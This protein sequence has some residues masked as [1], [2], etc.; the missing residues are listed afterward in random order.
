MPD[1]PRWTRRD[2]ALC[3]AL[4][5]AALLVRLP[6]LLTLPAFRDELAEV[7]RGVQIVRDQ[8]YPLVNMTPEIGPLFNYL[9]AAIFSITGPDP[10]LP[11]LVVTLLG[12][13][14]VPLTYALAWMLTGRR[15]VAGIAA[16]LLAANAMHIL[17]GHVAWSNATTPFWTT[18]ALLAL[19]AGLRRNVGGERLH[20][21]RL[22]AAGALWGLAL[23]THPTVIAAL[24]GVGAWLWWPG[25]TVR[26]R[27]RRPAFWV[28]HA[29]FAIAYA[30]PVLYSIIH[31]F[32]FWT[33]GV[34]LKH[35]ALASE[36]T[37]G[38]LDYGGNA[39]ALLVEWV[40]ANAAAVARYD[41]PLRY[42]AEPAVLIYGL[43]LIAGIGW[44]VRA[45]L[46]LLLAPIL[47]TLLIL[48]IIN[49]DYQFEIHT[50]YIG[51]LL[52]LGAILTAL[53]LAWAVDQ[54]KQLPRR[55]LL[56]APA[57]A[58]ALL[59]LYPLPVLRGYYAAELAAGRSN[60]GVIATLAQLHSPPAGAVSY[61]NTVEAWQSLQ[62]ALG[63][64]NVP[65]NS[66]L[67]YND[68]RLPPGAGGPDTPT[69]WRAFVEWARTLPPATPDLAV[70]LPPAGVDS[71]RALG[72]DLPWN[73]LPPTAGSN[74]QPVA[75]V[76]R[77]PLSAAQLLAHPAA[78]LESGLLIV[79][80]RAADATAAGIGGRVKGTLDGKGI[81]RVLV[82][83]D[84]TA[85]G[86][87][88]ARN[89]LTQSYHLPADRLLWGGYP[90]AYL[91]RLV[92]TSG[93]ADR[94]APWTDPATGQRATATSQG[95]TL[96]QHLFGTEATLSAANLRADLRAAVALYRP[97]RLVAP[98]ADSRDPVAA[99][100]GQA[101]AYIARKA[102]VPLD[103]LP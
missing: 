13:A 76:L 82:L 54:G 43:L 84:G 92:P 51:F 37:G 79:V 14:T 62:L 64:W 70:V 98:P 1:P 40:R 69:L 17:V 19:A 103:V 60:T 52:P 31:P 29:A 34:Q 26:A 38:G 4:A 91:Q 77:L 56:V 99:A 27:L 15:L 58:T 71:W 50:R 21:R 9:L 7:L 78:Q 44:A 2:S 96:H 57:L 100:T 74:G 68:P 97:T 59:I 10:Y 25:P 85:A 20:P 3:A 28:A 45:R 101:A 35:Y 5:L 66:L 30:P 42:L 65:N 12:A 83:G 8:Q 18:A 41:D 72:G 80:P 46:W 32:A 53:P 23:Q 95:P 94:E 49:R 87:D 102:G 11:R 16:A 89:A 86:T 90:A 81:V 22:I 93:V 73:A 67:D 75:A 24:V 63:I 55:V 36:G 6:E 39:L 33:E 47:S 61:V 48:P 88:L